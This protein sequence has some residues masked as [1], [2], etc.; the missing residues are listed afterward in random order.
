MSDGF[1]HRKFNSEK[2]PA[3]KDKPKLIIRNGG[4]GKTIQL[5]VPKITSDGKPP[6]VKSGDEEEIGTDFLTICSTVDGYGP[7][8]QIQKGSNLAPFLKDA[9][10]K[11][12]KENLLSL[13][14]GVD[15]K[16]SSVG[17]LDE[18]EDVTVQESLSVTNGMEE[19][20]LILNNG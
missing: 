5:S 6:P 12:P 1:I 8:K 11:N 9:I 15:E 13:L 2:C 10:E 19:K 18:D 20:S 4:R 7:F 16:F 14:N 3:L 17:Y